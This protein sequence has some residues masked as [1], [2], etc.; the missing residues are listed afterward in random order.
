MGRRLLLVLASLHFVLHLRI[1]HRFLLCL[2][3]DDGLRTAVRTAVNETDFF[4]D[5]SANNVDWSLERAAVDLDSLAFRYELC[6]D[7]RAADAGLPGES[8]RAGSGHV[9]GPTRVAADESLRDELP[10]VRLDPRG[11]A[12]VSFG[13]AAQGHPIHAR[14]GRGDL[15]PALPGEGTSRASQGWQA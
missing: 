8:V 11:K 13:D 4:Q 7:H 15:L 9:A 14:V 10:F 2:G 12:L 5:H 3:G 6:F 1:F